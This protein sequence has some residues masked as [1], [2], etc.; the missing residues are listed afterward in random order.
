MTSSPR[1]ITVESP[2]RLHLGFVDLNGDIGRKFGSLGLALDGLSTQVTAELASGFYVDGEDSIRAEHYAGTI[3]QA[4]G[5]PRELRLTVKNAIP[6]HAGLGSGTQMAL[7]IAAAIT[8]LFDFDCDLHKLAAVTGRGQRSGIGIGV[9]ETG[10]FVFDGGHGP[11]TTVPPVLSRFEFPPQ[12]RVVLIHDKHHLGLSGAAET[13]AFESLPPMDPAVAA[14]LCRVTLLG[15][16]PALVEQDFGSFS[17]HIA[18]IQA[19]IGAHF[20]ACQGGQYTSP[21]VG[22]AVN[23]VQ[24]TQHVAGVGQTSWGPTGFAF[25]ED[26]ARAQKILDGLSERFDGVPS[27][28]Y[29]VHQ[30]SNRGAI[31][32]SKQQS[33]SVAIAHA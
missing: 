3:L 33:N 31:I 18:T 4:F 20:S 25:V 1:S 6:T 14:M 12:W 8:E 30:G 17:G 21:A 28:T 16:F 27:L 19:A 5:L 22:E 15:V 32:A 11:S 29:S 9:F 26:Q 13:T 23:W 7:A 24:Q 2:A 10:G